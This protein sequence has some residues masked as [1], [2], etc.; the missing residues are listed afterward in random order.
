[1]NFA[2]ENGELA[3]ILG[4]VK[5]CIPAKSTM[6]I[7]QHVLVEASAGKAS[8]RGTCIDMEAWA[9]AP[10]DVKTDGIAA[11]PGDI[12]HGLVRRLPKSSLATIDLSDGIATLTSG[13]ASYRFNT[14]PVDA[15]PVVGD[16]D[17][18]SFALPAADLKTLLDSTAPATAN[19]ATRWY[20]RGIYLH[21]VERGELMLAAVATDDHRFAYREMPAPAGLAD[22]FGVA[23]PAEA[24]REMVA[25][26]D[27]ADGDISITV[28]E[29]RIVLRVAGAELSA[30]VLEGKYPNYRRVLPEPNGALL[31]V[32]PAGLIEAVERAAIV[33]AGLKEKATSV[34]LV[35]G[36]SGLGIIAGT[37]G[38]EE[39]NELIEA[40]VH[41]RG[42]ELGVSAAYL[43]QMLKLWPNVPIEVQSAGPGHPIMFWSKEL[44][45][46][47]Q[48]I[49]PMKR[50]L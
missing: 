29:S 32:R 1:M 28:S 38:H 22:G 5:G 20:H 37:R 31:T 48:L 13:R 18:L 36:L 12:L 4:A 2:M 9:S 45:A 19:S 10:A 49:M 27:S 14:L 23:V 39:V 11:I 7:L 42:G 16:V 40:D 26:L 17:G 35:P 3:R 25:L 33:C 46:Y 44:P 41:D 15:F 8:V 50:G 24:A 47:R 30:S 43:T 6:P 21:T 34:G